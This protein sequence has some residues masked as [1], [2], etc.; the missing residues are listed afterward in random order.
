MENKWIEELGKFLLDIGK[1]VLTAVVI[2][3]FLSERASTWQ[4]LVVAIFFTLLMMIVGLLLIATANKQ[5]KPRSNHA[6]VA[7]KIKKA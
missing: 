7:K 4:W 5:N 6:P 1:Y 2:S 3:S